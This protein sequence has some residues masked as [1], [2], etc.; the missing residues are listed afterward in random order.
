MDRKSHILREYHVWVKPDPPSV[1]EGL[2]C[3]TNIDEVKTC[4][5]YRCDAR[6]L[7]RNEFLGGRW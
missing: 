5:G 1:A 4:M 6:V 2:A 3:Q 7:S